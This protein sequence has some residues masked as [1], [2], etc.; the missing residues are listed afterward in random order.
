MRISLPGS[1]RNHPFSVL[2]RS[3]MTTS[4]P[5]SDLEKLVKNFGPFPKQSKVLKEQRPLILELRARGGSYPQIRQLL[6]TAGLHVSE[7]SLSKFCCKNQAEIQR[8]Q[9]IME[10]EGA[11]PAPTPSPPPSPTPPTPFSSPST[12]ITTLMPQK[13]FRDMR[14][15]F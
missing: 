15:T 3:R 13:K 11:L 14:G 9:T 5:R 8:L 7:A 2:Y 12:Q 6:A 1:F 10:G 4:A